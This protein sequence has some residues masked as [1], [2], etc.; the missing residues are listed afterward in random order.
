M[1]LDF[2][3]DE[4]LASGWTTLD[5]SGCECRSDGKFYPSAARV[6]R[7]FRESGF[8]IAIRHVQIFDCYRAEW[9]DA[10]GATVGAVVGKSE[11]EAAVY[12]LA[13]LRRQVAAA[14]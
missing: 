7:E 4:L 3:I 1:G 8:S 13:Q 2:A 12:A 10:S 11:T 5:L 6:S 14:C 9:R